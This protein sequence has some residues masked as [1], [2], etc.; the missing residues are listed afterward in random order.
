VPS[1][2][3]DTPSQSRIAALEAALRDRFLRCFSNGKAAGKTFFD[4]LKPP[5]IAG[6]F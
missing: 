6:A 3:C 4:S 5:L 1:T 2:P